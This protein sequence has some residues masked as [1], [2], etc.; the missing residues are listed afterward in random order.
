MPRPGSDLGADDTGCTILHVDMDAFYAS[1]ELRERPELKGTPVVIGAPGARGVVLSATY[2]A[3]RFGVHSAMPMT[4]ARRLCPQAVIIPPS[5]EKY[6]E[7]SRG[8]M[9]IF[10]TFTPEVEPIASDEAFLDVG[11]ARKRLGPP[12]AIAAMIREQVV[13]EHGITCSVGVANSK[14]V[15]KLASQHCK[16]DGLLVVPADRVVDFLHPLPVGALWGVGERTEQSLVRLG[17]RTVGDLAGVPV[18]TLQRQLGQAAGAHLAALAWGRDERPVTPH[19]PDKSI[20]AEETFATDVGDPVKIRRELLRL[21]ER[22][23]ARLREGGHV[24]RTVSVKLRRADFSTISR[25][26]T[27][28]EPTDVAQ[29]L[30][31]TACDLYTA[32]GLDGDRLRLVGVR[33]ENL[34]PAGEATRQLGLGERETG[35]REAEQAMDRAARRFGRDVVLPASLVRPPFDGMAP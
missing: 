12:A 13:R 4:R 6:A 18:A 21:S 33:V 30:Y 2:E 25:S 7:V 26:R 14:F 19:A 35:W 34:S 15:A 29:T 9:E 5:R 17:I 20:G 27:L 16:P 11:G 10:H 8:V 23:A 22:V 1:V 32:A 28:R 3:R 31:A 24:G